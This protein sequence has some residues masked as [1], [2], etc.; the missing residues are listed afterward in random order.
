MSILSSTSGAG[1]FIH[2]ELNLLEFQHGVPE[3]MEKGLT[4]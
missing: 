1:P 2:R 3:E 4:K